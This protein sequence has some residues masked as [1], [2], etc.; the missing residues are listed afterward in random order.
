[1]EA[2]EEREEAGES[3]KSEEHADKPK[4]KKKEKAQGPVHITANGEPI[5]VDNSVEL[6]Q[7]H[8]QWPE[9]SLN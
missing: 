4:K 7:N 6:D 5:P 2:K 3:Y 9:V 8:P 1:M